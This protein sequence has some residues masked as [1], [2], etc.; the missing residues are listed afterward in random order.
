MSKSKKLLAVTAALLI[1]SGVMGYMPQNTF[2]NANKNTVYATDDTAAESVLINAANFPDKKFGMYVANNYDKN[3]DGALSAEEIEAAT[4]MRISS[5]GISD[6]TG[7]EYLTRLKYLDCSYTN[8]ISFDISKNTALIELDCEDAELTSLDVSKNTALKR[9]YCEDNQ[10]TSLD[11]SNNT[12][13]T[14]LRCSANQLTSLDVSNNTALVDF[15]CGGNKLTSLDVSN[16][17]A[18]IYFYCS[19]NKL[20]S[21]D[22]S[23][24]VELG[25][26]SC[27]N[28]QLTSLDVSQ[29]INLNQF[30]CA[31]NQLTSLDLSNNKKFSLCDY[32]GNKY[33]IVLTNGTFDLSTLPAGFDLSKVIYYWTN[34]T[35]E[36]NILTVE[37]ASKNVTYTYNCGNEETVKFTLVPVS[38]YSLGDINGDST[39]D[40]SDASNVLAVYALVST[41][42]DSELTEEQIAAA[43]VNKDG[44]IDASDASLILAYYAYIQTGG[45]GTLEEYLN[46]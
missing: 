22:I 40:A 28:N 23:K 2:V 39:V 19:G 32:S 1:C 43:D 29:N 37:D 34:G 44:S 42:K 17:T 46:S 24:N 10:L 7:I 38:L 27:S 12:A 25:W 45:T 6:L 3:K 9:L 4:V 36:G 26:F 30:Y 16:N 14:E 11:L 33:K 20:T 18:L 21:L 41:G 5:E 31:N 8:L 15:Y 35:V 13:L